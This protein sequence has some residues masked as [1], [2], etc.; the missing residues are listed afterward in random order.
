MS[1]Y[2]CRVL[3]PRASNWIT[4]EHRSADAAALE[5]LYQDTHLGISYKYDPERPGS[6][7]VFALIEVEEHGELIARV[8]KS[9]IVRRGGVKPPGQEMT[10]QR[11]AAILGWSKDPGEL[12]APGWDLEEEEWK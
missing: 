5:L 2:R 3:K 7:V 8:Y 4:V 11:V 12:L 6:V 1:F 10:I 9:S